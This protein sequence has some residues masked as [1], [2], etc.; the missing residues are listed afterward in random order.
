VAGHTLHVETVYGRGYLLRD[1]PA[2][3]EADE[4]RAVEWS[5]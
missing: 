4:Q 2:H 5:V 1:G 3:D